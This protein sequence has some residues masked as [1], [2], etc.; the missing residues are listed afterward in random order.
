MV[1]SKKVYYYNSLN[2]FGLD[3]VEVP[4]TQQKVFFF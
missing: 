4:F 1:L 2:Q 3:V